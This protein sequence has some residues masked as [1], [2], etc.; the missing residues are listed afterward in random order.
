V[1][2]HQVSTHEYGRLVSVADLLGRNNSGRAYIFVSFVPTHPLLWLHMA[3]MPPEGTR[4]EPP[5]G[6]WVE[7]SSTVREALYTHA[8]M[9]Q[10]SV[11]PDLFWMQSMQVACAA[12]ED[13]ALPAW[14]GKAHR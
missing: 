4:P 13:R 3:S 12:P 11:M 1:Q 2:G 8:Y 10:A 7:P 14:A 6:F 5:S 9:S